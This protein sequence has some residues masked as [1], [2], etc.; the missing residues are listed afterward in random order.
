MAAN[1]I[2]APEE[3]W[4]YFEEHKDELETIIYIVADNKEYGTE[5]CLTSDGRLPCLIVSADDV[6][7][8]QTTCPE[9]TNCLSEA[10]R[11]FDWYLTDKA[12][13]VI[14]DAFDAKEAREFSDFY[15]GERLYGEYDYGTEDESLL[16]IQEEIEDRESDLSWAISNFLETVLSD[17]NVSSDEVIEIEEDC[18]EHFLEYIHLK[19]GLNIYRPMWIR[20]EDGSEEFEEYPY[21][22]LAF[23]DKDNPIYTR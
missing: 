14:A 1:I 22:N 7:I 15:D 9:K 11:L 19:H 2:I 20:Y 23:D 4:D 5:I 17:S 8:E 6:E 21:E 13:Q 18:L 3:I 16:M 10:K 12:V